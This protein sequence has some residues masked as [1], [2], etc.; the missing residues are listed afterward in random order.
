MSVA[1]SKLIPVDS[2]DGSMGNVMVRVQIS[3]FKWATSGGD[4][5]GF[6]REIRV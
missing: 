4:F 2:R 1:A 6:A 5:R 3:H